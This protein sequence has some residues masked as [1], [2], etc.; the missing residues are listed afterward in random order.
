MSGPHGYEARRPCAVLPGRTSIPLGTKLARY[1]WR[2]LDSNWSH[3][4]GKGREP[5]SAFS[6]QPREKARRVSDSLSGEHTAP[7][8]SK[9]F[10]CDWG[11]SLRPTSQLAI[12]RVSD[13]NI[14][15]FLTP[16][17]FRCGTLDARMVGCNS[18]G[19]ASCENPSSQKGLFQLGSV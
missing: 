15:I 7:R 8:M 3:P 13:K 2:Y 5:L 4:M 12:S 17:F 18:P 9:D 11:G 6:C 19:M 10:L 14:R 1:F 16:I